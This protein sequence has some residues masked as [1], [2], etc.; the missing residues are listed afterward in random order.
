MTTFSPP[1]KTPPMICEAHPKALPGSYRPEKARRETRS[2]LRKRIVKL[3]F[4]FRKVENP[5]MYRSVNICG[6]SQLRT[7]NINLSL[8]FLAPGRLCLASLDRFLV[9]HKEYLLVSKALPV[10][11]TS[12]Y[13]CACSDLSLLYKAHDFSS[14]SEV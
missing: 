7:V 11:G 5:S 6:F 13:F 4:K 14:Q 3:L 12:Y 1:R 8:H 2:L 10:L 9:I